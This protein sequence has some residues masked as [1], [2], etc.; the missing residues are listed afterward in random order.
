LWQASSFVV[1][2]YEAAHKRMRSHLFS[3]LHDT[4]L[5]SFIAEQ[6]TDRHGLKA[7]Q[8]LISAFS[9]LIFFVS[10]LREKKLAHRQ[11]D[12]RKGKTE[13]GETWGKTERAQSI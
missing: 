12:T 1:H 9:D 7:K 2:V 4:R 10:F 3:C 11:T 13:N 8:A 6:H 5:W